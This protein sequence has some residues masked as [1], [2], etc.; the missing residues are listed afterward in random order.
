MDGVADIA[1]ETQDLHV[2]VLPEIGA[3]TA[4]VALLAINPVIGIGTFLAQLFLRDPL[5][6]A[7]TFEYN[8]TGGWTD[9]V[10][11]KLNHKTEAPAAN[12][13]DLSSRR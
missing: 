9:P 7:F 10:V 1:H 4:S 8:I 11:T 5:M 13:P 6:R 3:G 12:M 2:A